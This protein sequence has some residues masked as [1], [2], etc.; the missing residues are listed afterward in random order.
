M[1][2]EDFAL[3]Q[4]MVCSMSSWPS[5]GYF[6]STWSEPQVYTLA[7]VHSRLESNPH[8]DSKQRDNKSACGKQE[9]RRLELQKQVEQNT[10]LEHNTKD[11]RKM[12]E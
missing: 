10:E 6:V 5:R 7:G 9:C 12:A 3:L 1:E 2:L 8:G 11:S 4:S